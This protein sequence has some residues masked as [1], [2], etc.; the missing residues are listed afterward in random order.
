[1]IEDLFPKTDPAPATTAERADDVPVYVH[2]WNCA[3]RGMTIEAQSLT[4][5][6]NRPLCGACRETFQALVQEQLADGECTVCGATGIRSFSEPGRGLCAIHEL[7]EV[8]QARVEQAGALMVA[9]LGD[10]QLMMAEELAVLL[11]RAAEVGIEA[12]ESI[13]VLVA[14]LGES[15]KNVA[16]FRARKARW[17][18]GW[19]LYTSG[20]DKPADEASA[21]GWSVASTMVRRD[22]D[23]EEGQESAGEPGGAERAYEVLRRIPERR[24]ET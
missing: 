12:Q 20:A 5:L 17:C 11:A 21:L 7:R 10:H 3:R 9:A 16:L 24:E 23:L 4:T 8:T 1:M 22:S 15:W 19:R 6:P 18:A 13:D 14:V 2:C